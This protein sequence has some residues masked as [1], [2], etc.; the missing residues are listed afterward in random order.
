LKPAQLQPFELE[1]KKRKFQKSQQIQA[2][3]SFFF[4]VLTNNPQM[5]SNLD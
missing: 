4:N 3:S 1:K 2:R 5:R